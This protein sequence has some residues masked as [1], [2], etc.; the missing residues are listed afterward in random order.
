MFSKLAAPLLRLAR[1]TNRSGRHTAE[2]GDGRV[3]PGSNVS[4]ENKVDAC[5][6]EKSLQSTDSALLEVDMPATSDSAN[7]SQVC[8]IMTQE[9]IRHHINPEQKSR[10][11]EYPMTGS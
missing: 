2:D 5:T 4:T 9:V 1:V 6:T 8:D 7:V 3:K 10:P 11:S